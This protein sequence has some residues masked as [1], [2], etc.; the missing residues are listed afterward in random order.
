MERILA[1]SSTT[2]IL[3]FGVDMLDSS[4]LSATTG[5]A[6][7]SNS[8]NWGETLFYRKAAL[9]VV[10]SCTMAAGRAGQ[11]SCRLSYGRGQ[12]FG[13]EATKGA[14]TPR[15][16]NPSVTAQSEAARWPLLATDHYVC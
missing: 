3:A 10:Q 15:L 12:R 16:Q 2:R 6:S 5:R 8:P 11:E 7:V 9:K 1:S 14:V 13:L 4:F